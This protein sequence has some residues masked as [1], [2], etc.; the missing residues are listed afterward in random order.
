LSAQIDIILP[1]YNAHKGWSKHLEDFHRFAGSKYQLRYILV[2]DGSDSDPFLEVNR[3]SSQI[4]IL[5]ISYEKNRGKG[6]ALRQGVLASTSPLIMYTDVDFPFMN[7]SVL[8]LLDLLALGQ[9]DLIAGVRNEKYYENQMSG[10]R[11]WLSRTFRF[12][13]RFFLR[14]KVTD[15]QCGLKGFN[16]K[17]KALFLST[18]TD[19][20]LFDF[21][22]IFKASGVQDLRI[23]TVPVTIREDVQFSKMKLRVLIQ[24]SANLFLILLRLK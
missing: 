3:L 16:A 21:E 7:E 13:L 22:F 1:C 2:N 20:Y 8:A 23:F 12:F 9:Y 6:Y 11:R 17:G 5:H 15:T 18:K 14:M 10:F 4:S 24:E 19:R